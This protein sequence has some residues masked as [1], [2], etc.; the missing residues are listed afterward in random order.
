MRLSQAS[1][2]YRASSR[3]ARRHCLKRQTDTKRD[4]QRE[5][6]PVFPFT[7]GCSPVSSLSQL[8][9][10]GLS[11]TCVAKSRGHIH[12]RWHHHLHISMRMLTV[13]GNVSDSFSGYF[14]PLIPD[15]WSSR[16]G[17]HLLFFYLY[18]YIAFYSPGLREV[19]CGSSAPVFGF[20]L[21]HGI[22][23]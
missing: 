19:L 22:T 21:R 17:S 4:R 20:N 16:P 12:W 3:T 18:T 2:V 1:L 11:V 15:S 23:I 5:D 13:A 14:S 8:I 6:Y 10:L 7:R 9:R